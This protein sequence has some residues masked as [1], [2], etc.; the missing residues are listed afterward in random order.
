MKILHVVVSLDPAQGGP[1][2]VALRLAAGQAAAG[3]EVAL[4]CHDSPNRREAVNQSLRGIPNI[5]RVRISPLAPGLTL[6]MFVPRSTAT[7]LG[8]LVRNADMVHLHG[9]WEPIVHQASIQARKFGRPYV[10]TL[11]GVLDPWCLQQKWLK[12]KLALWITYRRM[13]G[14]A[15]CLYALNRDEA[16]LIKPLRIGTPV[17]IFPNG[18]FLEELQPLPEPGA[19]RRS[20]PELGTDPYVLFLSRLH[21]KKGLDYLAQSFAMVLQQIPAARLVVA[22]PD[23]GEQAVF[24]QEV[25]RLGVA[26]RVHVVGPLWGR[27][28]FAA[29]VDATVFC[30]PSR[31]EGFS[32]A[33]TEALACGLPV[34]ISRECHFPEVAEAGAGVVAELRSETVAAGLEQVLRDPKQRHDMALAGQSLV[35][36][37]YTWPVIAAQVIGLYETIATNRKTA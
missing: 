22:G 4:A 15:A 3:H 30:L 13:L 25:K 8:N 20:H 12:K 37:R 28:K 19:F 18:V 31:Q 32:M 35:R 24:E 34:V 33:V 26:D 29:M 14:E 11:H 17:E 16:E 27:E 1:P 10:Q 6:K 7:A 23:G 36:R 21:F 5:E 9:V 2:A